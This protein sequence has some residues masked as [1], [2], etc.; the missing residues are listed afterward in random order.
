MNRAKILRRYQKALNMMQ[1]GIVGRITI[2]NLAALSNWDV[3]QL[4]VEL[5]RKFGTNEANHDAIWTATQD[6]FDIHTMEGTP[7]RVKP[8]ARDR[9]M[10]ALQSKLAPL[11]K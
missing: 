2:Q 5:A 1:K 3:C 4:G 8:E 9:F 6:A 10:R 11:V 7:Y